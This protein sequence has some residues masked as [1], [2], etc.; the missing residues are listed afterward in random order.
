MLEKP[1]STPGKQKGPA[2]GDVIQ[3]T[4]P[5]HGW[6]PALLIVSEPRSLGV[7]VFSPIRVDGRS[8]LPGRDFYLPFKTF[9][10]IGQAAVCDGLGEGG[11]DEARS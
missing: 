6:Y 1:D 10:T 11:P 4:D 3:V 2:S 7:M 9:E 8:A 5:R